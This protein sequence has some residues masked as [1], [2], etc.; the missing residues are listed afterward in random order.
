[1]SDVSTPTEIQILKLVNG[2]EIIAKVG[3]DLG[4]TFLESPFYVITQSDGQRM[5]I[6]LQPFSMVAKIGKVR[7]KDAHI[8]CVLEAEEE[9]ATQYSAG[10]AGITLASPGGGHRGPTSGRGL[11]LVE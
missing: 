8:L 4:G 3:K 2:A 10:L 6:A 9:L 5:A 11:T 1:M 7:I